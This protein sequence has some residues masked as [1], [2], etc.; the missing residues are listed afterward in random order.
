MAKWAA[1]LSH[2][3][4]PECDAVFAWSFYRQGTDEKAADSSDLF[5]KQTLTD[6]GDPEMANSAQHASDKG[7]R[8]AQLVGERRAPLI[9]DGVKPLQYAPTSPTA[10]QLKDAGLAALLKDWRPIVAACAWLPPAIPFRTCRRTGT[11]PCAR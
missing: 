4:W 10:G 9:L 3:G 11:R 5:L 6:F 2:Q 7:R 1:D 8:L